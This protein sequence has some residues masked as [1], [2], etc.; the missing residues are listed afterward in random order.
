MNITPAALIEGV[1]LTVS[2]VEY[3]SVPESYIGS[4]IGDIT[5][6]NTGTV[7]A[8]VSVWIIPET[9]SSAVSNAILY[10][11]PLPP[12]FPHNFSMRKFMNPGTRIAALA[13]VGSIVS[14]SVSGVVVTI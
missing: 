2:E 10:D 6:L 14:L 3:Y 8:T 12:K 4:G 7:D 5:I 1:A 9:S 11:F 13:S